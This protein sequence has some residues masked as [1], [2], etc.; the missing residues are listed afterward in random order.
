MA[1]EVTYLHRDEYKEVCN[2]IRKADS[3]SAKL[4]AVLPLFSGIGAIILLLLSKA[5]A[6]SG[7][8]LSFS[9][10]IGIFSTFGLVVWRAQVV[11]SRNA[12]IDR[13]RILEYRSYEGATTGKGG[14]SEAKAKAETETKAKEN[15]V[16]ENVFPYLCKTRREKKRRLL[17]GQYMG[18][19]DTYSWESVWGETLAFLV[20]C[21]GSLFVWFLPWVARPLP[22]S[23]PPLPT[24]VS[25]ENVLLPAAMTIIP[26][27]LGAWTLA[28]L[29]F[30]AAVAITLFSVGLLL[31]F[32]GE[33]KRSRIL[34][35]VLM[36]GSPLGT[37]TL[38]GTLVKELKFDA[39]IK[40]EKPSCG[41]LCDDDSKPPEVHT[42]VDRLGRV[43]SFQSGNAIC[44]P[45]D[46]KGCFD[47]KTSLVA[48]GKHGRPD[49][50]LLVGS[51]DRQP[52]GPGLRRRFGSNMGLARARAG[53]ARDNLK[54]KFKDV[55]ESAK[56][57]VLVSG[58]GKTR[59]TTTMEDLKED[60]GVEVWAIWSRPAKSDV[61]ETP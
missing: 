50:V 20:V 15:D 4:L 30:I 51:A 9:C 22:R 33:S 56:F 18:W 36:L 5:S 41:K 49:L 1:E 44:E 59:E 17:K 8:S 39:L 52:L 26:S 11:Q 53:W 12:F 25:G 55:F 40:F 46:G 57:L 35:A 32:K 45:S 6:I 3:L 14:N 16:L 21:I 19:P 37:L 48:K 43:G 47:I 61:Q 42:V 54:E 58:P 31:M 60:R 38:S 24:N 27:S 28:G 34:G 23:T 7:P 2:N 10:L 13:A 29:F